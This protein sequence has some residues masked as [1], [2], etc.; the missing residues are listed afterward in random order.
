MIR[1]RLGLL[2]L[3]F[4]AGWA[5][6]A[7]SILVHCAAGM[8]LPIEI[9]SKAFEAET[10]TKVELSYD[11]SNK[12]LGQIKLTRRGDVYIA[13]DADYIGMAQKEGFVVEAKSLCYFVPVIMVKKGNPKKIGELADCLKATVRLGQGDDKAAAIGRIMPRLLALN[14]IDTASWRKQV[15]MVTPTVNELGVAIKLGTL[16]AVVVWSAVAANY[17]DV[18]EQVQIPLEKNVIPEVGAATLRFS[19]NSVL[20]Q[21]FLKFLVSEKARK[22]L[23]ENHYLV[24]RPVVR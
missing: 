19:K 1:I 20:A 22:I 24:E 11:G 16:D 3:F 21:S 7:N 15:V 8:R 9:I 14:H 4:I 23:T 6:S 13:G 17:T 18:C 10:G 5:Y 12:L 2:F